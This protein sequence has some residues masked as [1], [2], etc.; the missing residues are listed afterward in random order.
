MKIL[1]NPL[2]LKSKKNIDYN[3]WFRGNLE[4]ITTKDLN[5]I[6]SFKDKLSYNISNNSH[7]RLFYCFFQEVIIYIAC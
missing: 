1:L 5:S 3:N 2:I 6:L 4:G 7:V